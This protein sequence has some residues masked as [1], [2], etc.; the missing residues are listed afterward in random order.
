MRDVVLSVKEIKKKDRLLLYRSV[1]RVGTSV[2]AQLLDP[3]D[4]T[5]G[6]YKK[7]QSLMIIPNG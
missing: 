6:T 5:H 4:M 7:L 2:I 3:P 1:V